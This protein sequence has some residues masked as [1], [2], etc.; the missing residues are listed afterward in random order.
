MTSS[1]IV[2]SFDFA[3][4]VDTLRFARE[5]ERRRVPVECPG[6][7]D[8]RRVY[9][10]FV[11]SAEQPFLKPAVGEL[12]EDLNRP[13]GDDVDGYHR[14]NKARFQADESEAGFQFG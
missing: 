7:G 3:S 6:P 14:A 13:V 12:V 5:L 8:R 11:R 2:F 9:R 4:E 1:A 10:R